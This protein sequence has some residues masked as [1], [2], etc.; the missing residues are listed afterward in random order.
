MRKVAAIAYDGFGSFGLGVVTEVFGYDRTDRGIPPFEL[1]ICAVRPG[2]VRTDTG[3]VIYAEHALDKVLEADLVWVLSWDDFSIEVPPEIPE[4]LCAAY[5]RGAIIATH[6][7][8]A[9]VLAASGLLDGKR[10][11]THWRWAADLAARFP[12]LEV[13]P[14][15][16]Y[17]D[18][19]QLLTS[20]GVT[21]AVDLSLY[22][23]RREFGAA[24][25]SAMGREMV[26]SPHR[27]GG[28]AQYIP[29]PVPDECESDRLSAVLGWAREH[30][31]EPI[32]VDQL[33]ARVLMSPRSFARHFKAA[34][35]T[36]PRA[37][38]LAQRL[39]RAE[40]LL[41]TDDLPVEEIARRVGFGTAAALRE[42][43]VRRR[44]VPPRDY[45]RS[46][47]PAAVR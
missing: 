25:A 38:L 33:A 27:D 30:L 19:G 22:L 34:T 15:V 45:R 46:F 18:E 5:A 14:N 43:F 9:Y 32:S 29:A 4:V 7:T 2:P 37:W 6:C 16:L 13:D 39:H 44:G 8:G 36:T 3:L 21:A 1:S 10:L 40:E 47:R 12:R 11:T 41:E 35:G 20:A 26:V 17:V 23:L 28:Q 24:V 31:G 42:Q